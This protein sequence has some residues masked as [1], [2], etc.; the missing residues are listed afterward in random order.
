MRARDT[1]EG[2]AAGAHLVQD[3]DTLI[4]DLVGTGVGV[5]PAMAMIISGEGQP[6]PS[7]LSNMV[8]LS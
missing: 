5:P 7:L 2:R 8:P 4:E 6:G 3:V 1:H